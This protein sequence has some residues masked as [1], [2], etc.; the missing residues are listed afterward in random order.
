MCFQCSQF[1]AFAKIIL[2]FLSVHLL[3][4]PNYIS[5]I[6]VSNYVFV[7]II[8]KICSINPETVLAQESSY[9]CSDEL[10]GCSA[11]GARCRNAAASIPMGAAAWIPMG[12][13]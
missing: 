11:S 4:I 12:A 13:A 10:A 9:S 6:G 2:T 1:D 3:D 7:L 5:E 8:C